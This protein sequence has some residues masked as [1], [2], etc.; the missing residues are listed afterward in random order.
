[1]IV[2]K[3]NIKAFAGIKDKS[4]DLSRGFN[5]IYGKTKR[6]KVQLRILSRYGCMGLKILEVN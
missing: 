5:L 3:I 2:K 6:E 1:M 4:L